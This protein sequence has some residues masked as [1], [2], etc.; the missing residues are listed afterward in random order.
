MTTI[1]IDD[2]VASALEAQAQK[3]GVSVPDYLRAYVA[4]IGDGK[5]LDWDELER[6]IEALSSPEPGL[7]ADFSRADMYEDH[8]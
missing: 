6:E 5:R 8:D 2:Q 7:P 3:A 1:Q 4:G